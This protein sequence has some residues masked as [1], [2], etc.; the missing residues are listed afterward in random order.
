M[1][2]ELFLKGRLQHEMRENERIAIEGAIDHTIEIG[3][4]ERLVSRGERVDQ[5]YYLI[6]GSMMRFIDDRNGFRQLVGVQ[7]PGDWVDLH[8]FPMKRLDH[9]VQALAPS[10]LA[11]FRHDV[12]QGLVDEHPHLARIMWFSTLLDAAMH[13]E[14]IFRLG[15]LNAE[16]RIAH[17]I[18]ELIERLRMVGLYEEGQFPFPLTQQDFGEACGIST[19]HANRTFQILKEKGLV[20]K[21][22]GTR[23]LL[24]LD[25]KGL[26]ELGE[27]DP[28]YLYGEGQL[29]LAEP[30]DS[31]PD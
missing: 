14:W 20:R 4:R 6:E 22:D 29:H 30:Y 17:L 16:G 13:R 26:R 19:I 21:E 25:E 27:F 10:K 15:R 23:S 12:L 7:V 5:S 1:I 9:D 8:S 18:C 31:S 2:T 11:V 28:D 3:A 24:V